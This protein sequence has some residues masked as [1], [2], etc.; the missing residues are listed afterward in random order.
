[1]LTL[2]HPLCTFR[3]ILYHV[4]ICPPR[5]TMWHCRRRRLWEPTTTSHAP[6][7][8]RPLL[9]PFHDALFVVVVDPDA[10]A[11]LLWSTSSSSSSF[12]EVVLSTVAAAAA[13]G[14][15]SRRALRRRRLRNSARCGGSTPGRLPNSSSLRLH[16]AK[17]LDRDYFCR[18]SDGQ[19]AASPAR[20]AQ[21]WRISRAVYQR[22]RVELVKKSYF[23]ETR[24]DAT[25]CP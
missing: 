7:T 6:Q 20:F 13:V 23:D 16:A 25:R 8:P 5:G 17:G 22:I 3:P 24:R 9:P 4:S 1:M 18:D 10:T 14:L 11:Q 12:V 19:L 2:S 15:L 21:Q